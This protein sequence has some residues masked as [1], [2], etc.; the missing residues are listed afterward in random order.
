MRRSE[1]DG[2]ENI[3]DKRKQALLDHFRT[4]TRIS[5]ATY[6]EL[7]RVVPKNSAQ[8]VYD[9]FHKKQEKLP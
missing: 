3:G 4:I 9:Y 1:L 7:C 5:E 8:S 2:I 6:E